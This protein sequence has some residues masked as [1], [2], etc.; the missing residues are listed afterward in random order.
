MKIKLETDQNLTEDEIIIHCRELNEDILKLQQQ[1]SRLAS[2]RS[3]LEVMKKDTSYYLSPED[4]LFFESADNYTSV[5]TT[6]DIYRASY[7]LYELE[8]ILPVTFMRV[9]KSTILNTG[10]ILGIRK[11]LTGPSQVEFKGTEKKAFVSR[12]YLK[13]LT[14][15]LSQ[16]R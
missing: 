1:I 16:K 8:E 9:S 11:N 13:L 12:N 7:K 15:K 6:T 3:Q 14:E 2:E 4:I 5:H 10:K